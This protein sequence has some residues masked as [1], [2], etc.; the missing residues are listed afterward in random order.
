MSLLMDDLLQTNAYPAPMPSRVDRVETHISWV[1]LTGTDAFK[2][3]KPRSFGF[4]T[5]NA[6]V[7]VKN[8]HE[9]WVS[10]RSTRLGIGAGYAFVWSKSSIS[11][12]M[13]AS[14]FQCKARAA[15]VEGGGDDWDHHV[16][17]DGPG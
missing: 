15:G 3:K 13:G 8:T 11:R 6:S 1:F 12:L 10:T 2:V 5:L 4:L 9:M 17:V 14:W 16:V 7:P